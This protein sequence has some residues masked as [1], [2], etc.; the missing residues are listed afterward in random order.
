VIET[1]VFSGSR[2]MALTKSVRFFTGSPF[3]FVI[4]SSGRI[5]AFSAG[6]ALYTRVTRAPLSSGVESTSMPWKP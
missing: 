5:S 2:P 3:T 1:M 4:T 6:E